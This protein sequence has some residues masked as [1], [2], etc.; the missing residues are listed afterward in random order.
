[1]RSLDENSS[2][3]TWSV[4]ATHTRV[5]AHVGKTPCARHQDGS[6]CPRHRITPQCTICARQCSV[7][8]AIAHA[9]VVTS[10]LDEQA[11]QQRYAC[12]LHTTRHDTRHGNDTA[13]PSRRVPHHHHQSQQYHSAGSG[14]RCGQPAW[15]AVRQR[16]LVRGNCVGPGQ[17]ANTQAI[18]GSKGV[19]SV[20][21]RA[22]ASPCLLPL[23]TLRHGQPWRPVTRLQGGVT[24]ADNVHRATSHGCKF[25]W[26]P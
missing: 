17:M 16:D 22:C 8:D 5:H 7:C 1:M 11:Q 14:P 10:Q 13:D 19:L 26:L 21:T 25:A 20:R 2:S 9:P 15:C 23:S 4:A 3:L 12:Q 6:V 24:G 18:G